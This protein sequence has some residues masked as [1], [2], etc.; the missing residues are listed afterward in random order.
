MPTIV[1][2]HD[3]TKGQDH[4]L[5]SPKRKELFGPLGVTNIRTFV[6]PQNPKRVAVV[7][8]VPDMD[9]LNAVM[10]TPSAA[11][12]MAHD[13]V[14][15]YSPES[16][17]LEM[18]RVVPQANRRVRTVLMTQAAQAARAQHQGPSDNGFRPDPPREQRWQVLPAAE[19]HRHR[20]EQRDAKRAEQASQRHVR[21]DR[22]EHQHDDRLQIA[23]PNA[24]QR[25][26]AA[27]R[28]E[29]HADA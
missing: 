5:R 13:G 11:E 14:V 28:A 4:W 10:Q 20:I 9:A 12:A 19:L 8:D 1:G 29:R 15:P 27:A 6:D 23:A 22:H 17:F 16:S 18:S 3:I 2:Y 26:R 21:G 25:L 24:D 7:M